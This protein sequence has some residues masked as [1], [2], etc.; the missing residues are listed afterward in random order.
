MGWGVQGT[1][2]FFRAHD[3]VQQLGMKRRVTVL[4]DTLYGTG[5]LFVEEYKEQAYTVLDY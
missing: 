1:K 5:Y 4:Q 2:R 3:L